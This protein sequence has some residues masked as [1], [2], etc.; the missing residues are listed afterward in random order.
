MKKKGKAKRKETEE[1]KWKLG[2]ETSKRKHVTDSSSVRL[3]IVIPSFHFPRDLPAIPL[4]ETAN[5]R[6]EEARR[7]N[8]RNEL[9]RDAFYSRS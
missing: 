7:R 3:Q 6:R 1:T 8:E 9:D 2:E 4:R 5:V